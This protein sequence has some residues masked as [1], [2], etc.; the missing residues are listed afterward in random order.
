MG[1]VTLTIYIPSLT[2]VTSG[3]ASTIYLPSFA[4]TVISSISTSTA[5]VFELALRT[6]IDDVTLPRSMITATVTKTQAPINIAIA[7]TEIIT[8]AKTVTITSAK[9]TTVTLKSMV[10][11][12][13]T[14]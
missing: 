13:R 9:P 7:T 14:T 6:A 5:I 10:T 2:T 4:T 12:T 1:S 3:S 11:T 8:T